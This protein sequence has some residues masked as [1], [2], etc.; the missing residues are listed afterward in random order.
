MAYTR[1]DNFFFSR[2][3]QSIGDFQLIPRR[4]SSLHQASSVHQAPLFIKLKHRWHRRPQASFPK[5]H[6]LSHSTRTSTLAILF[7]VDHRPVELVKLKAQTKQ[8]MGEKKKKMTMKLVL[9]CSLFL[10]TI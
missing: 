8:I 4:A 9:T 7:Y 2:W 5:K 3:F 6:N 10:Y 1:L